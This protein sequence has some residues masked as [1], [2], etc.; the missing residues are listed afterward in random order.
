MAKCQEQALFRYTWAGRNESFCCLT[1][2]Q[3]IQGVAQ[4]MGYY[5][6]LIPLSGDEQS[7]VS[8]QNESRLTKRE[9]DD[10]DSPVETELSNDELDSDYQ[11]WSNM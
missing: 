11:L 7:K 9:P 6:Q 4:A 8:C 2:A 5:V 1:H 10:G 3:Q